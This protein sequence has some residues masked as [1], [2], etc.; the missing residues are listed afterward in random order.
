MKGHGEKQSRTEDRAILALLAEPTL[1]RAAKKCG[2]G[3]TTL[4]RWLQEPEFQRHYREARRAVFEG[5]LLR[6]QSIAGEAVETLQRNLGS[7]NPSVE[8]RAA[9]GILDQ[10]AKAVELY[11]LQQRVAQLE[12]RLGAGKPVQ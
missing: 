4:W 3:V 1:E 12:D 9:L 10:A 2:I 8:V 11:E 6:L 7:K 5:T